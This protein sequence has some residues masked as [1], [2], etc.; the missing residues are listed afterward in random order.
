MKP[1]IKAFWKEILFAAMLFI[2]SYTM[3]DI[4]VDWLG[5]ETV[6]TDK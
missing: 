1:V 6:S 2:V 3:W 5:P 4:V